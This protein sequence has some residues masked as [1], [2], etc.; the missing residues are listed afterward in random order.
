MGVIWGHLYKF[1]GV[2]GDLRGHRGSFIKGLGSVWGSY[3][4][5]YIMFGQGCDIPLE[6]DC[7]DRRDNDQ[8]GSK[9]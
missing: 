2:Y 5:I 1:W 9:K 3:G 7:Y 6:Q 8:G 4:V